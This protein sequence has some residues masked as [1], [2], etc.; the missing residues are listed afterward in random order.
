MVN[1]PPLAPLH[2][3]DVRYFLACVDG[4][5]LLAGSRRC[6]VTP[7]AM[8]KALRRLED[9]LGT[10]LMARSTRGASLTTDGER[11]VAPLRALLDRAESVQR[12]ARGEG[13]DLGGELRILAMEVFSPLVL[14]RAIAALVRGHPRLVPKTYE[15]IPERMVELVAT[16]R[17]DVAFTIGRIES[18]AVSVERLGVTPGVLVCGRGHPLAKR[19]RVGREDV[20]R[21]PSVVPRFWGAEHLASLDQFPDDAWPRAVGATIELLRMGV[22]LVVEGAYLGYF[23][24]IAIQRELREGA[25]VPL[26]SPPAAPFELLALTP[27]SGPR[28][29]AARLVAEVKELLA[30]LPSR[31]TRRPKGRTRGA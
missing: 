2:L 7:A 19:R 14:P 3:F 31:T 24:E 13:A 26:S 6:R 8:T 16:G 5:S 1:T 30:R 11:L 20:A 18:F 29:S 10:S 23:P 4:G 22:A 28:P 17:A 15:S 12:E 25:L 27:R 9:A 21:F